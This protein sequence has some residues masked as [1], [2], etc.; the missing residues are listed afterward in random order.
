MARTL[1]DSSVLVGAIRDPFGPGAEQLRR[2]KA[3]DLCTS[4]VVAGELRFGAAKTAKPRQAIETVDA[5]L[6]VLKVEPLAPPIDE[7]YGRLRARREAQGLRMS[8]NDLWIAAHAMALECALGTADRDF[9]GIPG[10][11]VERW[12]R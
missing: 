4:V 11:R 12:P 2:S 7:V 3:A 10:L 8:A 9:E 1:L 5:L 6:A